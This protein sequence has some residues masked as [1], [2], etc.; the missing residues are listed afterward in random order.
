MPLAK[1]HAPLAC[2]QGFQGGAQQLSTG[3]EFDERDRVGDLLASLQAAGVHE[4]FALIFYSLNVRILRTA[5]P[6]GQGGG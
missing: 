5:M 4:L 3:E 1:R 6:H 2:G